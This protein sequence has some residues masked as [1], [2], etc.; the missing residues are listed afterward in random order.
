MPVPVPARGTRADDAPARPPAAFDALRERL[1][2]ALAGRSAPPPAPAP[3]PEAPRRRAGPPPPPPPR[4]APPPDEPRRGSPP[5]PLTGDDA[6]AAASLQSAI[7]ANRRL[8]RRDRDLVAEQRD[9]LRRASSPPSS[10]ATAARDLPGDAPPARDAARRPPPA[11]TEADRR[12]QLH[13]DIAKAR[14]D[15]RVAREREALLGREPDGADEALER[16]VARA[17]AEARK[18]AALLARAAGARRGGDAAGSDDAAWLRGVV[19]G[20]RHR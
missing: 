5:P 10:P 20:A 4:R 2:R 19:A 17:R 6:S 12:A 15:L 14:R 3:P 18:A 11:R 16:A 7:Q 13:A 1:G 9:A 8:D